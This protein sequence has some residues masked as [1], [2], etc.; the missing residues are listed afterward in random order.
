MQ[1]KQDDRVSTG[2]NLNQEYY[3]LRNADSR[4][5]TFKLVLMAMNA[6]YYFTGSFSGFGRIPQRRTLRECRNTK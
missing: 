2:N 5:P 4:K 6:N 1:Y 3:D